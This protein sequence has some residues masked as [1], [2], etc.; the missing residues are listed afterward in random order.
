MTL[1]SMT[2]F[3]RSEGANQDVSWAWE[4]KSVNARSI[5]MRVKL[6][7]GF[8]FLEQPVRQAVQAAVKRGTV[9][10]NLQMGGAGKQS[11]EFNQEMLSQIIGL[12]ENLPPQ[13]SRDKLRLE[14]LLQIPGMLRPK[15]NATTDKDLL[16][17]NLLQSFDVCLGAFQK[18][19]QQ[20]GAHLSDI[21]TQNIS[22]I[23]QDVK[24]A[25]K[26]AENQAPQLQKKITEQLQVLKQAAPPVDEAR[27]AQELAIL[28]TK[29]DVREELD[30]LSAHIAAA[31]NLLKDPES[32]GR[33]FDFLLQEFNREANTLCA[34]AVDLELTRLGLS[35]KN[36]IEQV[37][38]Q[39]QNVE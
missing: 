10:V 6:P 11:L 32:V 9:S 4:M 35:L 21:L 18:S 25:Y 19:R 33:R 36:S 1:R 20:E 26:A 15:E 2:G 38:E 7:E 14:E 29:A 39:V 27:L 13:I 16:R 23:E 5:D 8:D 22:R 30:R 24:A 37:R 17:E 12:Q 28:A 34:K 31:R 3:A